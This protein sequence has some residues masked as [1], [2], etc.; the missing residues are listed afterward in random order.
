[1]DLEF[2]LE[3]EDFGGIKGLEKDIQNTKFAKEDVKKSIVGQIQEW[4]KLD[5]RKAEKI[6]RLYTKE[7]VKLKEREKEK[8]QE[9]T[10]KELG[11]LFGRLMQ[12]Y[13][14]RNQADY[15][16]PEIVSIILE[17]QLEIIVDLNSMDKDIPAMRKLVMGIE[18]GRKTLG[19]YF[20][21]VGDLT[22]RNRRQTERHVYNPTFQTLFLDDKIQRRFGLSEYK[23][24][25]LVKSCNKFSSNLD[26]KYENLLISAE[27]AN[28]MRDSYWDKLARKY[29]ILS[30]NPF[31]PV[32]KDELLP[33]YG[34]KVW[35]EGYD[36][37]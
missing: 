21:F 25:K 10:K 35:K 12:R 24:R 7:G 2:G 9:D 31:N 5:K 23:A 29:R 6:V 26:K 30:D 33:S 27:D 16:M 28:K 19:A 4:Y 13:G 34:D 18:K 17:T 36:L 32:F 20:N 8:S 15:S 3:R 37:K 11:Y 14:L 22:E 1:M